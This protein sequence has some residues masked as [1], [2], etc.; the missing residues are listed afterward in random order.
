MIE[1]PLPLARLVDV[2][3]YSDIERGCVVQ[4]DDPAPF[5]ADHAEHLSDAAAYCRD[6]AGDDR[7][8]HRVDCIHD[9]QR[10]GGGGDAA[11][12][13]RTADL[14]DQAAPLTTSAEPA[15]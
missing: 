13:S 2:Y 1:S 4:P 10:F 12:W 3:R 7:S 9:G 6:L 11:T 14:I 8:G 15:N 5:L